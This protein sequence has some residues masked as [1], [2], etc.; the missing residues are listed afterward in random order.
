MRIPTSVQ[1]TLQ[2]LAVIFSVVPFNFVDVP[3]GH[4]HDYT[5]RVVNSP[6]HL[7]LNIAL[8]LQYN[9]IETKQIR[10]LVDGVQL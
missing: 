5:L 6:D 2:Y 3:T 1:Y 10:L 4:E 8:H 9:M 7:L